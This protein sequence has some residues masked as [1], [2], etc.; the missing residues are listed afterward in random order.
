[1]FQLSLDYVLIVW[2][3]LET[4][5]KSWQTKINIFIE[6]NYNSKNIIMF[7]LFE[8][9]MSKLIRFS[10]WVILSSWSMH[11]IWF[12]F[13]FSQGIEITSTSSSNHYVTGTAAEVRFT[14]LLLLPFHCCFSQQTVSHMCHLSVWLT[15]L[16][17][18]SGPVGL[19]AA[20]DVCPERS[21]QFLST[22]LPP[23]TPC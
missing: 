21:F 14:H 18:N 2:F 23:L 13:H 11:S 4:V 1:M 10:E 7:L 5:V 15:V 19:T 16:L 3:N 17:L 22:H 9:M 20:K 6:S 12:C 8:L